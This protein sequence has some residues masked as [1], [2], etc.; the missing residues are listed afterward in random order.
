M[1]IWTLCHRREC[2]PKDMGAWEYYI[3]VNGRIFGPFDKSQLGKMSKRRMPYEITIKIRRC[4]HCFPDTYDFCYETDESVFHK[5]VESPKP[6]I[7][8]TT[9]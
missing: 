3:R 1:K 6:L 5:A 7:E 9:E 4:K 2:D 8:L